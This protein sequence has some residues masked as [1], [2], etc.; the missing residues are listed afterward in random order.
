MANVSSVTLGTF[1]MSKMS[2][3]RRSCCS[4]SRLALR[5][6]S[7]RGGACVSSCG[8]AV[9]LADGLYLSTRLHDVG[10]G[11]TAVRRLAS[12][13]DNREAG[14][15]VAVEMSFIATEEILQIIRVVVLRYQ[16]CCGNRG[17]PI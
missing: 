16:K 5:K 10:T 13:I 1:C 7:P 6:M 17:V 3:M 12:C 14:R 4:L 11:G 15:T 2:A 8:M 9:L